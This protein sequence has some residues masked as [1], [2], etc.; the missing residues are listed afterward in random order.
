VTVTEILG[1]IARLP[2]RV[3]K[4]VPELPHQYTVRS[5]ETEADYVRLF[6]AIQANGVFEKWKGAQE[7]LPLSRRRG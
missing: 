7:A 4:T 1:V 2:F 6:N 3:A 5:P